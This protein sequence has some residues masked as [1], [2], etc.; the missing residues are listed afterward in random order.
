MKSI[1]LKK[2]RNCLLA[3]FF[4]TTPFLLAN[5][6]ANNPNYYQAMLKKYA[7]YLIIDY[8][9]DEFSQSP[10]FL[11]KLKRFNVTAAEVKREFINPLLNMPSPEDR[12]L[13]MDKDKKSVNYKPLHKLLI[14]Q[15]PIAIGA[16]IGR[17]EMRHPLILATSGKTMQTEAQI[18]NRINTA[19]AEVLKTCNVEVKLPS[20]SN[21]A[22]SPKTTSTAVMKKPL[23]TKVI[24]IAIA[25]AIAL[26]ILIRGRKK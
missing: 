18:Q 19:V 9:D 4:T 13:P 25:V 8:W 7:V 22:I 12:T 17:K 2:I 16:A 21:K 11:S 3:L 6:S 10:E 26:V 15:L 20:A 24:F 1:S 23:V 5:E 14:K